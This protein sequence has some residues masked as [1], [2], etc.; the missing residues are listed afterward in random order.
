MDSAIG[1]TVLPKLLNGGVK[2]LTLA[3]CLKICLM[4][5]SSIGD[6][7]AVMEEYWLWDALQKHG[8]AIAELCGVE[9]VQIARARI[10]ALINEGAYSFNVISQN[11]HCPF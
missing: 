8:Q 1:D 5:K 10:R 3:H 4:P 11:G 6:I 2:E 7:K 9:A